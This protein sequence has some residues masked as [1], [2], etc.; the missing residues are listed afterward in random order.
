M[1]RYQRVSSFSK[2]LTP[3]L[4]LA[5]AGTAQANTYFVDSLGSDSNLGASIDSP[6]ATIQHGID[7]A[8]TGDTI[9]V[10][11]DTYTGTG[12][13]NLNFGGKNLTLEALPYYGTAT[14]VTIDCQKNGRGFYIHS[15]ETPAAVIDGFSVINGNEG[16]SYGGGAYISNSSPT[17]IDCAFASSKANAGGALYCHSA[18]PIF[19]GVTFSKNTANYGGAVFQDSNSYPTFTHDKFTSNSATYGGAVNIYNGNG[20][21]NSDTFTGNS[22]FYGGAFYGYKNVYPSFYGGT[23]TGNK[24]SIQ[25]GAIYN[26]DYSSP[27]FYNTLITGNSALFGGGLYNVNHSSPGL[28]NVTITGNKATLSGAAVYNDDH[29]S[30]YFNWNILWNNKVGLTNSEIVSSDSTSVPYAYV[31]DIQG[32]WGG[33]GSGNLNTDPLF[34]SATDFHLK[35]TSPLIDAGDTIGQTIDDHDGNPRM[36]N[37]ITDLGAYERAL[38]TANND[39]YSMSANTTL[40]VSAANGVLAND[41]A[42]KGGTLSAVLVN[43]PVYGTLTLS[44]NGSFS[45]KAAIGFTGTQTFTYK[46]KNT[47]GNSSIATVTIT[48]I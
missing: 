6:F 22:A 10:I 45:Y 9:F 35:S 29:S 40:T 30:P 23:F 5:T 4:L 16:N 2:L 20:L 13:T 15:A 44:A 38:P 41:L 31:S 19:T 12:N 48:I 32:G 3:A 7:Y 37:G 17:F 34:V 42:N 47:K 25:G 46:A 43:K 39:S 14:M 28:V 1:S 27:N 24:A 18:S 33:A 11:A 26:V 36:C 8:S 21:F